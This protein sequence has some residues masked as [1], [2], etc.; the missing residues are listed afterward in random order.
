MS[1]RFLEE[2]DA[3]LVE[4]IAYYRRETDAAIASDFAR[5]IDERLLH[6]VEVPGAGRIERRAPKRFDLRWYK[7]R[8]FPYAL[9]IGTLHHERVVVAVAHEH[10]RPGY[11]RDR[12]EP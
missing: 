9:L 11:W 6:A 3:E 8:R 12:L 10:R 2:A 5:A 7:I 1:L 4:A